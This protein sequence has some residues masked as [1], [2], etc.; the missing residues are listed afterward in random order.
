MA[1]CS[2]PLPHVCPRRDALQHDPAARASMPRRTAARPCRTCVHAATHCSTTLPH[3]R[4]CRDALRHDPAA[5]ASMP[6]RIA[7]RPCCTRVHAATHCVTTL[8][9]VR[10]RR[11]AL[12]HD[13]AACASIHRCSI[14]LTS[15]LDGPRLVA[16]K[17]KLAR[18]ST[19]AA[20][21]GMDVLESTSDPYRCGS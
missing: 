12:R 21:G 14:P 1:H 7:S 11:D 17:P 10:P 15:C 18:S 2:T 3:V 16:T 13:P 4:P 19:L 9:H 20:V 6:R 5:R 8:L